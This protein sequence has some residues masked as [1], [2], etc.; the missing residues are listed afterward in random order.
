MT[1]ASS[2]ERVMVFDACR[3]GTPGLRSRSTWSHDICRATLIEFVL[4]VA[5]HSMSCIAG[6]ESVRGAA[7]REE[8]IE[9]ELA[10]PRCS[11]R[12]LSPRRVMRQCV[13]QCCAQ[14]HYLE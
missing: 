8:V 12:R 6:S 1:L 5:F 7:I 2:N 9:D 3:A 10:R 14:R 11:I 4:A 13:S